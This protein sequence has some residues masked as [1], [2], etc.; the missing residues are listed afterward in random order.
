MAIIPAEISTFNAI[1]E[2]S[3]SELPRPYLGM[4][5]IGHPCARYLWYYLHW[6]FRETHS[7]R[8]MRLFERGHREEPVVYKTLE[9]VGIRI[10]Q[11]QE[12]LVGAYGHARGHSDGRIIG[13]HEA[14]KTEHLLEIKTHSDKSFKDLVRNGVQKSKPMHYAQMQRYMKA[15]KLKRALYYAVNKNDDALYLERVRYDKEF[16]QN[17]CDKEANIIECE[18]PPVRIGNAEH[19]QCKWCAAYMICHFQGQVE[20]NCRTCAHG[21]LCDDGRWECENVQRNYVLPPE[22]SVEQQQKGCNLYELDPALKESAK[23]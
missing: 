18:L 21:A 1:A 22:L 8:V 5:Q 3:V 4:S 14:P 9:S 10:L 6:A 23:K 13:V 19:F 11:T 15:S 2:Q 17:L 20:R 7:S 16:A 12:A